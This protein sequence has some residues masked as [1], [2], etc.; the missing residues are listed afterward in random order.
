MELFWL[1]FNKRRVKRRIYS[2]EFH[3][4][5]ERMLGSTLK[6]NLKRAY[7]FFADPK[8]PN[9]RSEY[10]ISIINHKRYEP[11]ESSIMDLFKNFTNLPQ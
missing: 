2:V 4:A 3:F 8:D 11:I 9:D 1:L 10:G 7:I 5:R 6:M